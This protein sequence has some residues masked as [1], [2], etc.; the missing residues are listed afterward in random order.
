GDDATLTRAPRSPHLAILG[1]VIEAHG[2]PRAVL[3]EELQLGCARATL[4]R[5]P[6]T[7]RISRRDLR[8]ECVEQMFYF[9]APPA[10]RLHL[11]PDAPARVSLKLDLRDVVLRA[12]DPPVAIVLEPIDVP[13][14]VMPLDHLSSGVAPEDDLLPRSLVR[15]A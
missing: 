15:R 4:E 1:V 8:S 10:S 14:R 12:N 6:P 13:A 7:C 5:L 11:T 2:L 9:E 3:H